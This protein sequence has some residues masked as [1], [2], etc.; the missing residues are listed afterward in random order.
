[1]PRR[2]TEMA[3]SH[4]AYEL[5]HNADGCPTY[6]FVVSSRKQAGKTSLVLELMASILVLQP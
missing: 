6:T 1:M 4:Y 2:S 3:M 5:L